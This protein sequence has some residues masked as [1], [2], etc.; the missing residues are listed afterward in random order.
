LRV[1]WVR[2]NLPGRALF[3]SHLFR[4]NLPARFAES[5]LSMR[6]KRRGTV[7]KKP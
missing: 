6:R 4:R 3:R 7:S 5:E 2:L 1:T